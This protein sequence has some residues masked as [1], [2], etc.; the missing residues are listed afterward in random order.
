M[1]CDTQ[2]P[3]H[4]EQITLSLLSLKAK[5]GAEKFTSAELPA[6]HVHLYRVLRKYPWSQVSDGMLE[7]VD[8]RSSGKVLLSN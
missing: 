1:F 7:R 8:S 6:E 3:F 2:K 4:H 5:V